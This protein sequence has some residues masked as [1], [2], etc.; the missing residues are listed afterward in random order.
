[1]YR[2]TKFSMYRYMY[3]GKNNLYGLIEI[4]LSTQLYHAKLPML[5]FNQYQYRYPGTQYLFCNYMYLLQVR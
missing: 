2:S 5:K 4:Q 3:H 1:M